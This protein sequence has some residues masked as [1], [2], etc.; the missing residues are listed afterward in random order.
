MSVLFA[1]T[2]PERTTALVL[3]GVYAKRIWSPD[4]P[5][6]P[7]PDER[8]RRDRGR[9]SG[10]GPA[11]WTSTDLAPSADD[12]FK[13]RAGDVPPAQREPR[14]RGRP[15]ADEHADRRP[16]RAPDDPA[17]R[18]SSCTA[19]AIA[20]RTSRKDAGS[21]R[22]S[23]ARS[24]SSSPATSTSLWAGD[25]DAIL[26]E[27]EEFLTGARRGAGA[28][29]RARD[30]ALHGH[31]R[32]D[33]AGGRARRPALARARSTSITSCVRRE[34]ERFRGR[35]IDTAGDGFFATFDGPAAGDPVRRVRSATAC[36]ALGLEIRAG[37]HTGECEL[38]RR[39]GRRD[40][41]PHRRP[42][43]EPWPE[44]GEVLVSSTV[45]TSSPAP[46]SSSRTAASTS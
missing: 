38:M 1:A 3:F 17:S 41:C 31:R 4:Y 14:R 10:T 28:G 26:D 20:T 9:S 22:R 8:E 33:R 29:P 39:Q 36:R 24:S 21:P 42:G 46:G 27:V 16:R 25:A 40:R 19:S 34:L 13:A 7:T 43:R 44:P 2:Y 11:R 35:E 23:R 5:W 12:A 32:L 45:R 37:V 18:P 30:G 15:D 6:A